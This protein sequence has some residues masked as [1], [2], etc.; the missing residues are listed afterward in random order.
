[1]ACFVAIGGEGRPALAHGTPDQFLQFGPG[2]L[3]SV[4]KASASSTTALRQEFVPAASAITGVDVC[5]TTASTSNVNISIRSGTAAAPGAVLA[6]GSTPQTASPNAWVHVELASPLSVTPGTP[7]VIEV[8]GVPA[9]QWRGTC[10][11]IGGACTSVDPDLYP[12]GVSS[13]SPAVGDFGFVT[14]SPN[15][16]DGDGVLDGQDNCPADANPQQE[17]ADRDFIDLAPYGK[18]FNDLTWPNSDTAGD[19]CDS[20]DD[21][22]ELGDAIE[23]GLPGPSC[24]QASG[25]T[26]PLLRD[27]DGDRFL[28]GAECA[29]GSDPANADSKPP[30]SYTVAI[31][32]DRDGL[33]NAFET[34]IG[35][36]A[37]ASDTDGD[38]MLDG[39]EYK[40]YNT[41]LTFSNTDADLCTDAKEAASVDGNTQVNVIDMLAVAQSAGNSTSPNYVVHFDFTKNGS[42]DVI[43]LQAVAQQNGSCV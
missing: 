28:D 20:D 23:M 19:A 30:A 40:H 21:N 29:L 4:L 6:S 35:S 10:G 31:D 33:P 38:K 27:T 32:T 37:N 17:N 36:N 42:I 5:L 14:Y 26:N 12:A 34:Q 39:L 9:F 15:D 22:D 43:D 24:P 41:S 13:A 16:A 18:A 2:C 25:P 1:V 3:Q 8:S 11:Q 7:L